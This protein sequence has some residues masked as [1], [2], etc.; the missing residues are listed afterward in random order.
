[1]SCQRLI[2]C[3]DGVA[4]L[5]RGVRFAPQTFDRVRLDPPFFFNVFRRV[6]TADT[7]GLDRIGEAAPERSR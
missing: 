6:P 2:C 3:S 4:K 5:Q 1:M 7:E